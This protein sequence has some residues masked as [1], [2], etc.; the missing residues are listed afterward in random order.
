MYK[1]YNCP[2]CNAIMKKGYLPV[3]AALHWAKDEKSTAISGDI[4][5]ST[6]FN[7]TKAK[8]KGLMNNYEA[9]ICENCRNLLFKY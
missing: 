6:I 2:D 7:K 4:P 3:G 9:Y 5:I 1:E 8:R